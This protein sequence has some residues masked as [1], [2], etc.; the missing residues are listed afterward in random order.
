MRRNT[1]I[2]Y[3]GNDTRLVTQSVTTTNAFAKFN[4]L[5]LL[6]AQRFTF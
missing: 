2:Y 4:I 3:K 1:F 5:V 6:P